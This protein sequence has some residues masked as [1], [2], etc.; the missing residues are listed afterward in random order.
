MV[1]KLS[2]GPWGVFSWPNM[3]G[4][5]L[6]V[7]AD[8][9]GQQ[10]ALSWPMVVSGQQARQSRQECRGTDGD[11]RNMSPAS[12]RLDKEKRRRDSTGRLGETTSII[13]I[14][15]ESNQV[16]RTGEHQRWMESIEVLL[17]ALCKPHTGPWSA[18]FGRQGFL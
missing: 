8:I 4:I 2:P 1:L 11:W 3:P 6:L 15:Q 12:T 7:L 10:R 14:N 13:L 9:A 16:A 5:C 17:Q 18:Y